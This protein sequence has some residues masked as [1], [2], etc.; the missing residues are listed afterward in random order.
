MAE[1]PVRKVRVSTDRWDGAHDVLRELDHVTHVG[2]KLQP[3]MTRSAAI[4]ELM[5][6][7]AEDLQPRRHLAVV[8]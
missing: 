5:R 8:R 2:V 3:G 7:I 1:T 4:D 6:V